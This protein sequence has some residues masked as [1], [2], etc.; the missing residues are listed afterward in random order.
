M[1]K[2]APGCS[3][4][5]T[6]GYWRGGAKIEAGRLVGGYCSGPGKGWW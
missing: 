2:G 4:E 6:L 5:G 3:G 1:T